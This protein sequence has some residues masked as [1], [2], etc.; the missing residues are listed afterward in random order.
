LRQHF[1]Q[2]RLGADKARAF[3]RAISR[4][5]LRRFLHGFD[6]YAIVSAGTTVVFAITGP[7]QERSA[8]SH[9]RVCFGVA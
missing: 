5:G 2:L 4:P 6:K 1:L 9:V 8:A 3:L 7:I